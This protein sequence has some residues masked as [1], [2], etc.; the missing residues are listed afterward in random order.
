MMALPSTRII[1]EMRLEGGLPATDL[2]A[3]DLPGKDFPAKDFPAK[4][5]RVMVI[6]LLVD[7]FYIQHYVS[8][9]KRLS[10]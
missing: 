5:G 9:S 4:T 10:I 7:A 8:S 3:T 2:S 6:C 1:M